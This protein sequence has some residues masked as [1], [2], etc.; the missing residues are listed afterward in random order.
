MEMNDVVKRTSIMLL[1]FVMTLTCLLILSAQS[2]YAEVDLSKL[3]ILDHNLIKSD[4]TFAK[5]DTS[6]NYPVVEAGD[7]KKAVISEE[8][9]T[10]TYKFTPTEDGNY[11]FISDYY[12]SNLSSIQGR[13]VIYDEDTKS[14]KA[15]KYSNLIKHKNFG[16]AIYFEAKAGVTYYLQCRFNSFDTG[17]FDFTVDKDPFKASINVEL[18]Q[19]DGTA[20]ITGE[21]TGDTFKG[22]YFGNYPY[23]DVLNDEFDEIKEDAEGRVININGSS[24]FDVTINMAKYYVWLYRIYA[25]VN[26]H[27][28]EIY[29]KYAVPAYVYWKPL[30]YL[31]NFSTTNNS[32]KLDLRNPVVEDDDYD[33]QIFYQWKKKGGEWKDISKFPINKLKSS[34]EYNIRAY[35]GRDVYYDNDRYFTSGIDTNRYS[36]TLTL[37]TAGDKLS[38]KKIKI[39]KVKQRTI[40]FIQYSSGGGKKVEKH[41]DTT[42]KITVYLN[43]KPNA[44]GIKIQSDK[45]PK[46]AVLAGNKKKYSA[47]M[48]ATGKCKGKKVKFELYSYQSNKYK[49]NSP[50]V[51][52]KVRIK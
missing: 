26:N 45:C 22:L 48:R 3:P 38:I 4:S 14:L 37:K 21:V 20:R 46:G 39:S 34:T 40:K 16:F 31:K 44:A 52:K 7:T 25:L 23:I 35:Y 13:I 12:D 43:K 41:Y 18:N 6:Q 51:N 5:V 1:A 2:T 27:E 47:T 17:S 8:Y 36:K 19:A 49:S 24:S 50:I 30:I 42:F 15:W 32:I 10:A 33:C 9:D 11:K 29:Y 28:D